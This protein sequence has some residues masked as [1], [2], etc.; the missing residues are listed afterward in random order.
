MCV[1][2]LVALAFIGV[3]GLSRGLWMLNYFFDL[4]CISFFLT[5]GK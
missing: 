3:V 2:K 1:T 5:L 4:A